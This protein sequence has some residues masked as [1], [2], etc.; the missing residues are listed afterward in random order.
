MIDGCGILRPVQRPVHD[1]VTFGPILAAHVLNNADV[2]AFDDDVGGVV[3]TGEDGAQVRALGVCR[4]LVGVVGSAG[5]EDGGA[6]GALGHQDYRVE[7]DA[8]PHRDHGLAAGVVEAGGRGA[9]GVGGL[10]RQRRRL[11]GRARRRGAE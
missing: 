5:E 7:L 9:E 3:V 8:V 6:V 2:A 4:E 1:V 10:A 11:R